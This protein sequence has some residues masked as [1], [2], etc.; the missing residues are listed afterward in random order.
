MPLVPL[1]PCE[2]RWISYHG[3][4]K[5]TWVIYDALL[6]HAHRLGSS[7]I[8]C[9]K[10][11]A[12]YANMRDAYALLCLAALLPMITAMQVTIKVLQRRDLYVLDLGDAISDC[13]DKV[14][15]MYLGDQ[16]FEGGNFKQ[17][18]SLECALSED[19]KARKKSSLCFRAAGPRDKETLHFRIRL[20]AGDTVYVQLVARPPPTGK[21][22]RPSTLP[23]PV[24][25]ERFQT[26]IDLVKVRLGISG[27]QLHLQ[28]CMCSQSD[29]LQEQSAAAAESLI[30]DI[31]ARFPRAELLR[32]FAILH[33]SF[34]LDGG[35][36]Q[37][38][39]EHLDVLIDE[40][41]QSKPLAA[42]GE[43][44]AMVDAADLRDKSGLFFDFAADTASRKFQLGEAAAVQDDDAALIG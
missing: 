41:G 10:I 31:K 22:G 1:R 20:A 43:V 4:M 14:S 17:L 40:F 33:P 29:L 35:T 6:L 39:E 24:K 5:R 7:D 27:V 44:P 3:P 21:A 23:K 42:G 32:A 25:A 36:M 15:K 16:A 38:F 34:Y 8:A 11:L 30:G 26:L 37:Q 2:T 19:K 12:H 28:P 18:H 9:A 13:Q